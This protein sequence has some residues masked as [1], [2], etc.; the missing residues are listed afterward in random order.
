MA[1]GAFVAAPL[2]AAETTTKPT[3]AT[4]H[5]AAVANTRDRNLGLCMYPPMSMSKPT[6]L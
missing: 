6:A 2:G 4:A 1:I 5:A 3:V